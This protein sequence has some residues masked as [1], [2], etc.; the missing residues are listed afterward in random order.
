MRP[1]MGAMLEN[2]M[3]QNIEKFTGSTHRQSSLVL[4]ACGQAADRQALAHHIDVRPPL[5][6]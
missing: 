6:L 1:A 5:L 4:K 2:T 3:Q